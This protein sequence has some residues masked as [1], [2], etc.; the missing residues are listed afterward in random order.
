MRNKRNNNLNL[1]INAQKHNSG[2][3]FIEVVMALAIVS[4]ALVA[5]LRLHLV[6]IR[7]ADT[8][9]V[10]S[11]ALMLAREKI[12]EQLATG[13]PQ[14]STN[15][16]IEHINSLDLKWSTEV[17]DA[18]PPT[19]NGIRINDLRKISVNV[20]WNQGPGQ[21]EVNLSTLVTNRNL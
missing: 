14:T 2:F 3:T 4:I 9:N 5:L 15:T 19:I 18:E 7:M 1:S 12:E 8:S 11:Q 21:K 16:G 10:R 13:F 17:T 20:R 6:S